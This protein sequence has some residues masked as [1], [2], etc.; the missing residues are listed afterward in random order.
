VAPSLE[1]LHRL[2][3]I[4]NNTAAQK[5]ALNAPMDQVEDA[6]RRVQVVSIAVQQVADC[7]NYYLIEKFSTNF[8]KRFAGLAATALAGIL[9]FAWSANP[10]TPPDPVKVEITQPRR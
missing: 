1:A 8:R 7:A 3:R 5:I 2:L 6:L 10:D 4:A 9:V